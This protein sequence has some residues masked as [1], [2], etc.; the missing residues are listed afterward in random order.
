MRIVVRGLRRSSPAWPANAGCRSWAA[1]LARVLAGAALGALNGALVAYGRMPSIV[2]TLATMVALRDGAALGDAG[3]VGPGPAAGRSSG[4]GCPRTV[5]RSSPAASALL[6]CIA[7]GLGRCV[8]SPRAAGVYA[9]GSNREAARLAG[10]DVALVKFAVFAVAGA[11]TGAGGSPERGAIQSDPSNTGIGLEMKVIA[12]VVVGGPA[13]TGGRGTH[14]RHTCSAS[15]CSGSSG[16]RSTFLG[17]SAYWERAIQG[18]II[19]AAVAADA[20]EDRASRAASDGRGCMVAELHARAAAWLPNGEW[21]LLLALVVEIAVFARV[22][23]RFLTLGQRSSRYC[24]SA[25]SSG[26]WRSR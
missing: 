23:P 8:T 3:R 18:A 1:A 11:L 22:A 14:R 5:I 15:R 20:C 19:L 6:L 13:M 9:V 24:G 17:V 4:S 16:R 25:S 21:T 10:I 12:A 2:V 26:C 7:V